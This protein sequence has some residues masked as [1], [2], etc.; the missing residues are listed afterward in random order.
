MNWLPLIVS[1]VSGGVGG[2]IAGALM[3]K[4][5]LVRLETR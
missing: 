3:Q 1:L 4:F 2:N 5:N